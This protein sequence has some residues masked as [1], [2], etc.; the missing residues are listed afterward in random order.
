MKTE[1]YLIHHTKRCKACYVVEEV[2][3]RMLKETYPVSAAR[4]E[5]VFKSVDIE[6]KAGLKTAKALGVK[7]KALLV[8]HGD[9]RFDIT[10]KGYLY[11]ETN[12]DL[13]VSL[14]H[15][16]LKRYLN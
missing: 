14:Y 2:T 1:I 16:I 3:N 11:A 13:L 8:I 6:T 10:E 9:E 5:L 7:D 4:K 12:P 15:S